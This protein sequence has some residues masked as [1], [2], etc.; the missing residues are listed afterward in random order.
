MTSLNR[1]I[2]NSI[3]EPQEKAQ[4][5]ENLNKLGGI[6]SFVKTYLEETDR[7]YLQNGLA[8]GRI[9]YYRNI[10]GENLLPETPIESFFK[11]FCE[12]LT[13]P[14]LLILIAAAIVSLIVGL[15]EEPA[16][17]WTEG[18]AISIAVLLVSLISAGNDYSKQLQ[19]RELEKTTA[20]DELSSVLRNKKIEQINPK[21]IVIG[22]ILIMQVIILIFF[23]I[24]IINT[25]AGDMISADSIIL[26]SNV[27]IKCNESS[28]TGEAE[29]VKKS[30]EKD[31][32]LLSSC[33]L[34]TIEG[35]STCRAVVIGVGNTTNSINYNNILLFS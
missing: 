24:Y 28:L 16:D 2:L 15:I 12:A 25:K 33:L 31:C 11:I 23:K 9:E 13:D 20:N 3:N 18:V 17:G 8:E 5:L 6:D 34:N 7:S 10:F 27:M 22:D 32:F 4:N 29:D 30:K 35:A 19:F 14:V 26:D 1:V 21:F